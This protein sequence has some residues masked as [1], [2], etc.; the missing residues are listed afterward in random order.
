VPHDPWLLFG[1]SA[2]LR[3]QGKAA[4]ADQTQSEFRAVWHGAGLPQVAEF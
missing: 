4:A 3:A 1:L 2:A